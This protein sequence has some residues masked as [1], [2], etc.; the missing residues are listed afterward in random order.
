M[1]QLRLDQTYTYTTTEEPRRWLGFS[2]DTPDDAAR[3]RFLKRFGRFPERIIYT[4]NL[5]L[6]GPIH[7]RH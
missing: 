1:E 4:Q 3:V 7:E 6:V 2:L 5:K